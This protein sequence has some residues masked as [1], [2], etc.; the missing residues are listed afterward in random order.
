MMRSSMRRKAL[1]LCSY[2]A[3][4]NGITQSLE[5]GQPALLGS[6]SRGYVAGIP[7]LE[8]FGKSKLVR[9]S[10]QGVPVF[11]KPSRDIISLFK[12]D[13][14]TQRWIRSFSTYSEPVQM[15]KTVNASVKGP[16]V[17]LVISLR[18]VLWLEAC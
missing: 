4:N 6:A 2:A 15:E 3:A 8:A 1:S 11:S 13:F 10:H 18:L 5:R 14:Q 16:I 9:G 17:A 12:S 7:M